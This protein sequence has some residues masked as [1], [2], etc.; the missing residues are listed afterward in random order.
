MERHPCGG[1]GGIL[2]PFWFPW[3][4]SKPLTFAGGVGHHRYLCRYQHP[5]G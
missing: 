3:V 2:G 1:W 5:G 4:Q